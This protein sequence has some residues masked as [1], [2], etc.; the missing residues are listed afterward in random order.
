MITKQIYPYLS[1]NH[2]INHKKNPCHWCH[3]CASVIQTMNA[4]ILN[5]IAEM[6]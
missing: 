5:S 4:E 6:L 2:P 3:P 1:G